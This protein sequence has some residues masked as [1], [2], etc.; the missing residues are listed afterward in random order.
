MKLKEYTVYTVVDSAVQHY[1]QKVFELETFADVLISDSFV[2]NKY[3]A[4]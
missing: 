1:L 4:L 2:L 3:T